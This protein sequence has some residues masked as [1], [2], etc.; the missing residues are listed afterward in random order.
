MLDDV[1]KLY[2]YTASVLAVLLV[3]GGFAM[4]RCSSRPDAAA[5]ARNTSALAKAE[6]VHVIAQARTDTVSRTVTRYLERYRADTAWRADTVTVRDTLRVLVPAATVAR[7]DS[8]IRACGELVSTCASE[9]RAAAAEIRQLRERNA[10]LA[11]KPPFTARLGCGP[12]YG[13]LAARDGTVH[14][15]VTVACSWRVWP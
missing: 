7:T 15:G 3:A 4:G 5:I 14:H 11:R 13:V 1:E 6:T 2:R 12:G 10:L 8:T 9:R